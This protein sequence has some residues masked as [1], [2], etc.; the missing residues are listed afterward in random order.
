VARVV[1]LVTLFD[2]G[3]PGESTVRWTRTDVLRFV[4]VDELISYATDA[5]LQVERLAGDHELGPMAP[6][7]DRAVLLARKPASA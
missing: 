5:G 4:T 1:T 3:R 2:E 7:S 6:G